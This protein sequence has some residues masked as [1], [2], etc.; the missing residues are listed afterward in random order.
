MKEI[1]YMIR[2]MEKVKDGT[3]TVIFIKE[4]GKMILS[5]ENLKKIKDKEKEKL[6]IKMEKF[7]QEIF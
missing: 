1:F 7:I 3:K 4:N 6:F 2:E 5:K